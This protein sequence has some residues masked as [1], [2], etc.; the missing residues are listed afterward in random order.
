M[1]G[2]P[3]TRPLP[4]SRRR[5]GRLARRVAGDGPRA[6]R[7]CG[8][9][10]PARGGLAVR[11]RP[12]RGAP[13]RALPVRR[14]SAL[15]NFVS[16]L[17][18][19]LRT[20]G[21]SAVGAASCAA[22]SARHEIAYVGPVNP[23]AIN[24]QK[25]FSK[26]LRLSGLG[27][28]FFAYS[29]RRL[30]QIAAQVAERADPRARLDYFHGFTPWILT[31]PPRPYVAW[32]DCTFR[33]YID[34]FHNRRQFRPADLA[35]IEAAEGQWLR[36]ARRVLFSS[37]WAR[38]RA[39][40]HY[41][42]DPGR[43]VSL[44][45]YG[46]LEAPED[47]AFESPGRFVFISTNYSAKGGPVAVEAF[48]QLRETHPDARLNIVGDAPPQGID[49]PSIQ[50][51]G[52]LRKEDPDEHRRYRELL[53]TATAI[54]HPTRGDV[55]PLVLIEAALFGCPAISSRA[56]AIPELVDDGV[57]GLLLDDP[58]DPVLV[59]GAMRRLLEHPDEHLAMRASAW[60]RARDVHS[61]AAFEGRLLAEV[62]A[63]LAEVV[64]G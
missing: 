6:T 37:Q 41:R 54:V 56:F 40:A 34:I 38:E 48:R 63:V 2:N 4:R 57:S 1:R 20:G 17:P 59:A 50:T 16:H 45:I 36:G 30:S 49:D 24:R 14:R 3:R 43:A 13:R 47:D 9:G 62:D 27:G 33:D 28:D 19:D 7:R 55:S 39:I 10:Q 32:S 46:A 60:R 11:D 25:A 35:R 52:F 23:P 8:A 26:A 21:F 53:A 22:L 42:L 5:R 15:I 18:R 61:L 58:T 12:L 64:S 44:G 31:Q 51:V 29:E